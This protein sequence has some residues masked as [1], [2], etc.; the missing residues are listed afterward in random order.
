MIFKEYHKDNY[1]TFELY[2][3]QRDITKLKNFLKKEVK[4]LVGYNSKGYDDLI[5][6][7]ILKGSS[8][9][10][11]SIYQTSVSIIE[12]DR[13]TPL[14]QIPDLKP[15]TGK[16]LDIESIDLMKLHALDKIGVSLKQ[17]AIVL[18]H[19][20]IQDFPLDPHSNFDFTMHKM[21]LEYNR[22]D[23]D[24]TEKLLDY[25]I[26]DLKLRRSVSKEYKVNLIDAS[27]TS[28]AKTILTT[29]YEQYSGVD[30]RE[31]KEL[32]T[33]RPF[34]HL[35][36]VIQEFKFT[37]PALIK[38]YKE[39]K[40]VIIDD[41]HKFTRSI[42]TKSIV[43]KMGQGG[44]HSVHTPSIIESDDDYIIL[45]YDYGSYYPSLMLK[46]NVFPKHLGEHFLTVL[47]TLTEQRLA[48]KKSGDKLTADTLKISI[49]SL[50]G[51][52]GDE[53]YWLYDMLA[54]QMVTING[55]LM[56]L[57]TIDRL[58]ALDGV[59]CIYSNTDGA[60]F[61][62]RR[63]QLEAAKHIGTEIEAEV[64][65]PLEYELY[66]KFILKD[67]NNFYWI[68]KDGVK[69]KGS[70][71]YKQDVTKGYKSPI[72]PKALYEY[73]INGVPVVDTIYGETDIYNFCISQRVSRKFQVIF[74]TLDSEEIIQ[75]TNRYFVSNTHGAIIKH[76]PETDKRIS[77][78]SRE[79]VFLLNTYDESYPYFDKLDY[80]YYIR[81]AQKII[82]QFSKTQLSLF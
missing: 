28:I 29:Y 60:S 35:K 2:E 63:D 38:M 12:R 53:K 19:D 41:E 8:V 66:D 58:E 34:I 77:L 64:G 37:Q 75:K 59:D 27:R 56:I 20:K 40:D 52:L 10:N 39:A 55:Q 13:N 43:H 42:T 5:L 3:G 81:E 74:K 23:V 22:N 73:F 44:I 51:L 61:R 36:D 65:I 26:P 7:H 70:F 45:D 47:R 68:N 46:Y 21:F 16:V 69:A 76:N 79:N 1:K 57:Y 62:V 50:Y 11:W 9:N 14:W 33:H 15:L 54:Q 25:S 18:R 4:A 17:A 32:R 72:I 82:R 48:A 24:I 78:M 67:V 6:N 49:N 31:F 71:V 30:R 80:Q